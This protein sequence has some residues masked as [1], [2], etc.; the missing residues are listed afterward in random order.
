MWAACEHTHTAL[1]GSRGHHCHPT[2]AATPHALPP[3]G[4]APG[5]F[6]M[7]P[8]ASSLPRGTRTARSCDRSTP[9]ARPCSGLALGW[10]WP[11][12]PLA[13]LPSAGSGPSV[14][15]VAGGIS[16]VRVAALSPGLCSCSFTGVLAPDTWPA[17][18]ILRLTSIFLDNMVAPLTCLRPLVP[19]WRCFCVRL[20]NAAC[21]LA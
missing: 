15:P 7:P 20:Q 5:L 9:L 13:A 21:A 3:G 6:S 8:A 4:W 18:P 10:S 14:F 16:L 11:P 1:L 19:L 17:Q 2:R 12:A